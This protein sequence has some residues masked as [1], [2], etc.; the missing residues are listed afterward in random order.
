MQLYSATSLEK[1][2][3]AIFLTQMA[4]EGPSYIDELATVVESKSDSEKYQWLGSPPQVEEVIDEFVSKGILDTSYTITNKKFG[5]IV[6]VSR[7]DIMDDQLGGIMMVVRG[8]ATVARRYPNKLL[9]D[10]L[11][12]GA[13][14]TGYD[15]NA[16]FSATHPVRGLATTVSNITTL[17]GT[18]TA[19]V[20]T[21]LNSAIA[22]LLGQL[23]EN[24][25][26][27][28]E[29]GLPKLKIVA[30][31]SFRKA[32]KET[33]LA[34][35][36]SSSSNVAFQGDDITTLFT[37]RLTGSAWYLLAV[38]GP[39]KPLVWQDR[40]PITF[41]A[42]EQDSG[43]DYEFRREIYQYKA[44]FR[45]NAGYGPWQKAVKVV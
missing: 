39:V 35:I 5:A 45:G 23:G 9:M 43:S 11:A 32:M 22:Q 34:P 6:E 13:T 7:D 27:I 4:L 42:L 24:G 36:I 2:L 38:D 25:E 40:E 30:P 31:L 37:P 1:G 44:R 15:G 17:T 19:A 29:S 21:D 3:R 14:N 28:N 20:A 8:L 26:P 12:N 10:A 16:Y 41:H 33:L 18:T